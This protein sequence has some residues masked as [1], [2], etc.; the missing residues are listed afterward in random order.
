MS[1]QFSGK[2][3]GLS[4][5]QRAFYRAL[6]KFG[7]D[8]EGA[9]RWIGNAG[10]AT[11]NASFTI[12]R[13]DAL[14]NANLIAPAGV[15]L[16]ASSLTGFA[17]TE[18]SGDTNVYDPTQHQISLIWDFGD[19]GYSR[20]FTPNIP[21][22][23]LDTNIAFGKSVAHVYTTP[24]NYTVQC[25]AFD[26]A[27]NWGTATYTFQSG[28]N[29]GPIRSQDEAFPGALTAVFSPAGIWTGEP[30]G[31]VRCT[32]IAQVNNAFASAGLRG[33]VLFRRGEVYDFPLDVGVG[34]GIGRQDMTSIYYSTYGTGAAP[35][36]NVK[37][38]GPILMRDV[39]GGACALDGLDF[40]GTWDAATETGTSLDTFFA[41]LGSAVE[42][43]VI[44]RCLVSGMN[45]IQL[46]NEG[47]PITL[48][49]SMWWHDT[50]TTNWKSY[51]ILGGFPRKFAMIG[52]DMAQNVDALTGIDKLFYGNPG[53]AGIGNE[54]G[55]CRGDTPAHLYVSC[56]SFFSRNGWS[57]NGSGGLLPT[58]SQACWRF[59]PDTSQMTFRVHQ[60]FD[61]CSFESGG[62]MISVAS[63]GDPS[64]TGYGRNMVF[65]KCLFVG[66]AY[67]ADGAGR[68]MLFLRCPGVTMRN[69][70]FYQ[71]DVDRKI[72]EGLFSDGIV[73]AELFARNP[74]TLPAVQ[75]ALA[76]APF[77]FYNNTAFL[78]GSQAR[79]G[80]LVPVLFNT[81]GTVTANENNVFH[82]PNLTTP[83]GASF[84]PLGT[85]PLAGFQARF[86]GGRW[87]PPPIGSPFSPSDLLTCESRRENPGIPG[88][89]QPGPV[90]NGE[91][92]LLPYPN[93][94]GQAGYTLNVTQAMMLGNPTQRHYVSIVRITTNRTDTDLWPGS[95]GGVDISFEPTFIRVT[96]RTGVVWAWSQPAGSDSRIGDVWMQLDLTAQLMAFE[97][98]SATPANVPNGVAGT[99]SAARNAYTTGARAREDFFGN[100][101][102]GERNTNG[103]IQPDTAD[104]GHAEVA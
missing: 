20:R 83:I 16:R 46:T 102:P 18:P 56:T 54:H 45:L 34:G 89:L 80:T 50:R 40:V 14:D 11:P 67:M 72:S 4:K 63:V 74:D 3:A 38:R 33:R 86:K 78:P 26:D 93:Y 98:G 13:V 43:L 87:Q 84:A 21:T 8:E 68:N 30:A 79:I 36:L 44:S 35:V 28:G 47:N 69:S 73:I 10:T 62:R 104:L 29:A 41:E 64:S 65:D 52:C 94:T 2:L 99:G 53:P 37:G 51:G 59:T 31:A 101:R 95:R 19:P 60:M 49:G 90:A 71:P 76:S 42:N 15:M 82:A 88:T 9:L 61:R 85:S 97:S 5:Q 77:R 81:N 22:A 55:P 6:R 91:S 17:V 27:G 75:A 57:T 96:N 92:I 100:V 12:T 25:W 1:F 66:S 58:I 70:Y 7:M 23:Q 24:G 103:T 32:T 39:F 48:Q